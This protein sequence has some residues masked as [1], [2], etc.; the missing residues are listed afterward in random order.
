[1]TREIKFTNCEAIALVSD[2]DYGFLNQFKWHLSGPYP[3]SSIDGTAN[4]LRM[5]QVV[6][7]HWIGD[8]PEGYEI[9][10]IDRDK[11]NN[12]RENLRLCTKAQNMANMIRGGSQHSDHGYKGVYP[13]GRGWSARIG[14]GEHR[15]YLGQFNGETAAAAAYNRAAKEMYGEFAIL[16]PVPDDVQDEP[17]VPLPRPQVFAKKR[18]SKTSKYRGVTKHSQCDRWIG[19]FSSNGARTYLGLFATE[20]EAARAW[21]VKARELFGDAAP[22][23]FPDERE[24]TE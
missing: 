20:E 11:L 10:H 1:M 14:S 18:N 9:D 2:E 12:T 17:F 5:H 13:S 24:A 4:K 19:Q 6:I 3:C 8:V 21:D 22:L 23:N 16:N 7:R 15:R